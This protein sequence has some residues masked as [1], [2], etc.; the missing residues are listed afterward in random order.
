MKRRKGFTLIELIVVIA[1]LAILTGLIIPAFSGY[2][3][4]AEKVTCQAN[5][6]SLK[7]EVT[8]AYVSGK[9]P[10]L[11]SAFSAFYGENTHLCPEGGTYTWSGD[12][13]DGNVICSIH[14]GD[15][16]S[17]SPTVSSVT[18]EN[19]VYKIIAN[20]IEASVGPGGYSVYLPI[21][22][23]NDIPLNL[24]VI[25]KQ[26]KAKI[27][28]TITTRNE[29]G[30]PFYSVIAN[31]VGNVTNHADRVDGYK[32]ARIYCSC[33]ITS[34]DGKTSQFVYITVVVG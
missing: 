5:R 23:S 8:A 26:K 20:G 16:S 29:V 33:T 30:K 10:S 22:S 19:N 28:V 9:Y 6:R 4:S 3:S 15:I 14:G 25:S 18:P 21:G 11:A 31:G 12:E 17:P 7:T 32:R 13:N 34:E 24:E 2:T 27:S 1:I